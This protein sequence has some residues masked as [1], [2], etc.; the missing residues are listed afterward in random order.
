MSGGCEQSGP[1]SSALAA[2]ML[3]FLMVNDPLEP[4]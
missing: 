3:G 4:R 2:A 1:G